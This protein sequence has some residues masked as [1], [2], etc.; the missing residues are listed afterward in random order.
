M[1][2]Y[3]FNIAE[4][5]K[6]V[7]REKRFISFL[8]QE[9]INFQYLKIIPDELS[10]KFF[11]INPSQAPRFASQVKKYF[12]QIY[13]KTNVVLMSQILSDRNLAKTYE[14]VYAKI[15]SLPL[16]AFDPQKLKKEIAYRSTLDLA[17]KA[18]A[19][20]AAETATLYQWQKTSKYKNL[21]LIA[22]KR[23]TDTYKYEF[24]RYPKN[25]PVLPKLFVL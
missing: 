25:R 5:N 7:G 16:S 9:N 17:L 19:L 11:G 23:S 8:I 21:I 13:P 1:F 24:F 18:F 6:F 4:A 22:G 3:N 12:Q 20:F 10:K 2:D 15:L 14:E